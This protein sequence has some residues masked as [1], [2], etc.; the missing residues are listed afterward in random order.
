MKNQRITILV[1]ILTAVVAIKTQCS[2]EEVIPDFQFAEKLSLNPYQKSYH[3]NDT[4]W[5]EYKRSDK[6]LYD[7]KTSKSV[8]ADTNTIQIGFFYEKCYVPAVD[9]GFFC[10]VVVDSQFKPVW[11]TETTLGDVLTIRTDC[12]SSSFSCKAGFVPKETGIFA[13][14]MISGL[15]Q[16]PNKIANTFSTLKF[17]FDLADCNNDVWLRVPEY[18]RAGINIDDRIQ[19]KERFV[20]AVE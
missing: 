18:S 7:E 2:K 13:I 10:D 19:K 5:I 1:I 12:S 3:I 17:R 16:C 14:S 6:F 20:F 15:E 11:K 8:L 9:P 4:I